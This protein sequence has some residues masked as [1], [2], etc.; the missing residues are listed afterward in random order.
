MRYTFVL[1]V[2]L[3]F[4]AA[5]QT[6]PL[7]WAREAVWYQIFP[8]RFNNGDPSNDPPL[9]SQFYA[10]PHDTLSPWEIHPWTS[11]WYQLQPWE[12]QNG[13]DLWYNI[14]RRRYGGDLQGIINKLDYLQSL[15]IT[16]LY[17]NPIFWS[18]SHHKYDGMMYHHVDPYLGPDPQGDFEIMAS[19][20]FYLPETWQWT[21]A[22]TLALHLVKECHRRGMRIIFDGVFNHLGVGS[23]PFQDLM[24]R[25]KESPYRDWFEIKSWD[26]P[27]A[28]TRFDYDGW[29]GVKSLPEIKEDESGIVDGP[30][31]YIFASTRRW[32]D[33]TGT[34]DLSQGIDGWRLDVAFCVA[35]PF[36]K[37]WRELVKGINPSAYLTAEVIDVPQKVAPY[38][39]G[40]EFDAIMNYNFAFVS[41][42][43]F[44]N[45][46]KRIKTS[47]FDKQLKELRERYPHEAYRVMQNLFGSHD[48]NRLASHIV[49]RDFA[50]YADWGDY[51]GKSKA[52]NTQ[53][54]TRK[55]TEAEYAVQKL[56]AVFQFTYIGAPMVYYGDEV[57]M[58][59]ANDPDCRK[60]ML[61]EELSYQPERF[62]ADGSLYPQP[63][64][65][66]VHAGML[67]HYRA[68]GQLRN[69]EP[70]LRDGSFETLL[71]ADKQQ[72]Y[73]FRRRAA[74]QSKGLVVVLNNSNQSQSVQLPGMKGQP[75]LL[76]QS[77]AASF[78]K[79]K[80][81]LP[82]LGFVI[83]REP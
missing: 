80:C 14:T 9:G 19:E 53:Y 7:Q 78:K 77:E 31:A 83:F 65:V 62:K 50:R 74:G 64:K 56:F 54:D 68:L 51:F 4:C 11:D 79:N 1:L 61:W 28:G 21:A 71:T 34:G 22:D 32:M 75:E 10:W 82:P 12:E 55:P 59:G 76:H 52:S 39:E 20:Q 63:Q 2:I 47:D 67:A 18:P 24:A 6:H 45:Q 23:E 16:A 37:A 66:A 48:A 49:N 8:D 69:N 35:H 57:G 15:G 43:Y 27:A 81:L 58:W 70:A 29:F 33:P 60:P 26:D 44:V 30:R 72:V 3:P 38:L 73:A 42:D 5:A 36:W 25:Q 13:K 46:Q 40:D 17:L 41:A